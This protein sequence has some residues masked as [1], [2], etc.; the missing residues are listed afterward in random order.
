MRKY[1]IISIIV[2]LVFWSLVQL[3]CSSILGPKLGVCTICYYDEATHF[4]HCYTDNDDLITKE[5]CKKRAQ[6]YKNGTYEWKEK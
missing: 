4:E 1:L 6:K 2:A 3:S 5:E